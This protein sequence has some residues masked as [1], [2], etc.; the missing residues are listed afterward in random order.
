M[1]QFDADLAFEARMNRDHFLPWLARKGYTVEKHPKKDPRGDF[2]VSKD[3]KIWNLEVKAE[4]NYHGNLA[5][6]IW[7]N[8]IEEGHDLN[9]PGWF[10]TLNDDTLLLYAVGLEPNSQS[11]YDIKIPKMFSMTMGPLRDWYREANAE[12]QYSLLGPH[13]NDTQPNNTLFR[14]IPIDDIKECEGFRQHPLSA[15]GTPLGK[16]K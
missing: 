8:F 15:I 14:P 2:L 11:K 5:I 7:S 9:S 3:G 10:E 6:E 12:Q 16:P 4:K 13:V 1:S